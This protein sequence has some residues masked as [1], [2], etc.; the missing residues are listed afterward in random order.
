[1]HGFFT[2]IAYFVDFGKKIEYL[3]AATN[4]VNEDGIYN[5]AYYEYIGL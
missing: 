2:D 4:Y 3:L 1:M 5:D